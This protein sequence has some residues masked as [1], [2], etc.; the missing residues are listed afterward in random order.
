M[1]QACQRL[2]LS[3]WTVTRLIQDGSLQAIKSSEAPNGH[4]RISEESLQRYISLQTVPAQG[5]R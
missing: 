5:A 4:Y 1:R 2:R 3:R